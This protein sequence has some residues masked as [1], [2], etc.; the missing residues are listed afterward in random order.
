VGVGA[1]K[2]VSGFGIDVEFGPDLIA[3]GFKFDF[4]AIKHLYNVLRQVHGGFPANRA[5]R[6]TFSSPR[7]IRPPKTSKNLAA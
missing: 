6:P 7:N 3:T 1:G 2:L 4:E 5:A